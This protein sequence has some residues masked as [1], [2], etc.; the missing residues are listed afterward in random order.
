MDIS[1]SGSQEILKKA[2]GI[3]E[4]RRK[5]EEGKSLRCLSFKF[6]I[7]PHPLLRLLY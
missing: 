7:C 3:A 6:L 5:K 2:E 1:P 4:G